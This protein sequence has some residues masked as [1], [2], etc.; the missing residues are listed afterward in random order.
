MRFLGHPGCNP[1][2]QPS[3]LLRQPTIFFFKLRWRI[4]LASSMSNSSLKG[5]PYLNFCRVYLKYRSCLYFE[6]ERLNVKYQT[7]NY[8]KT[9]NKICEDVPISKGFQS[10][11]MINFQELR[12]IKFFLKA[13]IENCFKWKRICFRWRFIKYFIKI[14]YIIYD[15]NVIAAPGQGKKQFQF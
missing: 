12:N 8:W 3:N 2:S 15:E 6:S 5:G 11:E 1:I 4:L 9:H 13:F 10:T 14:P 7:L